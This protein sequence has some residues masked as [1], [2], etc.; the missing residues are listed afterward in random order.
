MRD[1]LHAATPPFH[2][3]DSHIQLPTTPGLGIDLDE[4]VLKDHPA[5]DFPARTIG[6]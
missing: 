2:V 4:Q 3:E 1:T 6:D 5:K